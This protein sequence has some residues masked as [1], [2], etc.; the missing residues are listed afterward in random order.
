MD[1]HEQL[2]KVSSAPSAAWA[3]DLPSC[4]YLGYKLGGLS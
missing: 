2:V 1:C 3:K 4:Y